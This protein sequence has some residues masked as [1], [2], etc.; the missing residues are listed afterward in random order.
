MCYAH[1]MFFLEIHFTKLTNVHSGV[2]L[3]ILHPDVLCKKY[4]R[5]DVM[6]RVHSKAL[7]QNIL[8]HTLLHKLVYGVQFAKYT[9]VNII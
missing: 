3:C 9:W 7:F 1:S 4:A 5:M 2:P 6:N 8:E